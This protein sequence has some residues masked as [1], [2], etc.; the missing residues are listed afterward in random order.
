MPP[1]PAQQA[2][3]APSMALESRCRLVAQVY[4]V[5]RD[6]TLAWFDAARAG[7]L[8]VMRQLHSNLEA[9]STA[10]STAAAASGSPPTRQPVL[11][12]HV[13]GEGTSYGFVGSSALHWA[14]A[15]GDA[16][17]LRQL[18]DWGAAPNAQNKGGSTALHSACAH[19]RLET[20]S[21]LL[22]HGANPDIADC[23]NDTPADVLNQMTSLPSSSRSIRASILELLKV[24]SLAMR[25]IA[26]TR[27]R[28]GSSSQATQVGG[29]N[30]SRAS[31]SASASWDA[32]SMRK[33]VVGC[34]VFPSE[35][36]C[37]VDRGE[38][39][40]AC[41]VALAHFERQLGAA[42]TS[43]SAFERLRGDL[44]QLE[45]QRAAQKTAAK[46]R[47]ANTTSAQPGVPG[48]SVNQGVGDDDDEDEDEDDEQAHMQILAEKAK[49]TSD[50]GNV[51]FRGNELR[52]AVQCYTAAI[53]LCPGDATYY[54]NR[55][56]AYLRMGVPARALQ[57]AQKAAA[58]RPDWA[59][60]YHRWGSASLALGRLQDAVAAFRLGLERAPRDPTLESG[61]EEVLAA[62]RDRRGDDDH[63]SVDDAPRSNT[64]RESDA[65]HARCDG[66][67]HAAPASS[68]PT[69]SGAS[70]SAPT[71][72][73]SAS[74]VPIHERR[75]WFSCVLCDNR[76]RDAAESPCCRALVCG[77][78]ASRRFAQPGKCPLRCSK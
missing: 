49:Q 24:Q 58:L 69:A 13:T 9:A 25:M 47:R 10:A 36:A 43:D 28:G 5:S 17:M 35:D 3:T 51:A 32:A 70:V 52:L 4:G 21:L 72:A 65:Q 7:R 42:S 67:P 48:Q 74:F 6:A 16:A 77:T 59:K 53:A 75:P 62:I 38:L 44:E 26:A 37:P 66:A 63:D 39:V 23:C 78:C 73:S 20:A 50:K 61:L 18:L 27:S 54:S 64:S 34:G 31:A 57:D 68:P 1:R 8:R 14:A 2:A 15:N 55:S 40:V 41:R 12:V 60:P 11:L 46:A 19:L 22:Q 71:S 56:A 30:A 76:T 29:G 45:T 33:L